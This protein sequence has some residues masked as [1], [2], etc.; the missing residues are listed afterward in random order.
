MAT[1]QDLQRQKDEAERVVKNKKIEL[2]RQQI[3]D[4]DKQI[5]TLQ[6]QR[7]AAQNDLSRLSAG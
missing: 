4:L 1:V 5:V 2:V 3:I 6:Q 7:T